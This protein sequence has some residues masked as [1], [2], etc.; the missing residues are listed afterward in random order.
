MPVFGPRGPP[1][2]NL[3]GDSPMTREGPWLAQ[4]AVAD[5]IAVLS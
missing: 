5:E 2:D 3:R 4:V 1:M